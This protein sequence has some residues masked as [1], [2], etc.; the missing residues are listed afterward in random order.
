MGMVFGV[1]PEGERP[2]YCFSNVE[3]ALKCVNYFIK[4]YDSWNYDCPYYVISFIPICEYFKPRSFSDESS[5][6]VSSLDECSSEE[7]SLDESSSEEEN[8]KCSS[9]KELKCLFEKINEHSKH[10]VMKELK[11]VLFNEYSK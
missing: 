1:G 4:N 7:G 8:V 5:S 3:V 10:S 6:D 11:R 2:I 9:I